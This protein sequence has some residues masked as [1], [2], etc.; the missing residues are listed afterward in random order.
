MNCP[1]DWNVKLYLAPG[2]ILPEVQA[3]PSAV[4]VCVVL[5]LFN[6]LI[7]V[8]TAILSGLVPNAVVVNTDAPPGIEIVVLPSGA[9]WEVADGDVAYPPHALM[10]IAT[11]RRI[12]FKRKLMTRLL[13]MKNKN[14][15]RTRL[16]VAAGREGQELNS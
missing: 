13:L 16:P 10:E 15:L 14:S 8:P 5:S 3:P 6:Q 2:A 9:G 1:A 4:D 7:V 11:R 12:V